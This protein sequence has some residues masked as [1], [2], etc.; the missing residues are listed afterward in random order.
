MEEERLVNELENLAEEEELDVI[1][2]PATKSG[3]IGKIVVGTIGA[4]AVA[5]AAIALAIRKHKKA[6]DKI[7][8][9]EAEDVEDDDFDDYTEA[10]VPAVNEPKSEEGVS[11]K[12]TE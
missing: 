11:A 10:D 1:D 8:D 5:G 7:V 3:G 9:A 6:K 4:V 12:K 2:L